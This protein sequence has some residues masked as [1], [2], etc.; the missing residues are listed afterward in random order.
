MNFN[1]S[2][3]EDLKKTIPLLMR[4][5][6]KKKS[7]V[8]YLS[9]D[10]GVGKTT[11]VQLFLKTMG[12]DGVV[13]SPTYA[14]MNEYAHENQRFIHADLY[15][16]ADPEE[17]IYLDIR[18]WQSRADFIF[19]EWAEKGGDLLPPPDFILELTLNSSGRF[20]ILHQG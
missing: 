5:F 17:L 1:I 16:L 2:E 3:L 20:L 18:D 6:A 14:I 10:L 15:R 13:S 9:G 11:F 7:A 4:L 8:I 12:Y 19:I